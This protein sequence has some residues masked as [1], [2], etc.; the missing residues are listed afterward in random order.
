[1]KV[2]RRSAEDGL[3]VELL[4]RDEVPVEVVSR[5]LRY[6]VARGCSPN[7]VSAYAYDLL[8]LWRFLEER[9]L[10]WA[11]LRPVTSLDLLEFLRAE[12]AQSRAQRFRV[13]DGRFDWGA[14]TVR[15][16]G[17]PDPHWDRAFYDWA[18]AAEL[19]DGRR[20]IE[21]RPDPSWQRV[22]GRHRPFLGS[23]SRRPAQR[24]T[25]AVRQPIRL[26][27]PLSEEQVEAL[28]GQLVCRRDRA[29]LLVMLQGG[30]R[31]GEVLC[32]HLEDVA[33]GRRRV[34]VRV[35]DDH[36][37]G[38]R[39]NSRAER[40]VDLFEPRRWPRS[41]TTCCT[42]ALGRQTPRSCSSSAPAVGAGA[43]R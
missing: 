11:A 16:D 30:L 13:G 31:P 22:T 40:V 29:M 35:R 4:D 38:V 26:P 41:A 6:L 5:F 10:G 17:E 14:T 28:L 25:L 27:R 36:P 33:Y 39:A 1:M 42:N 34:T 12:P 32:L 43:S 8:H 7:T 9:T 21:R 3:E 19:F 24:R 18:I 2:R 37:G 20:P 15:G 23:A